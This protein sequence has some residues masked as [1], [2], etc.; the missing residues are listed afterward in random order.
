MNWQEDFRIQYLS[1]CSV[2]LRD[3]KVDDKFYFTDDSS[4]EIFYALDSYSHT[5]GIVCDSNLRQCYFD[6]N[7]LVIKVN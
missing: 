2:R 6:P 3:V 5:C 1:S 7:R 4:R